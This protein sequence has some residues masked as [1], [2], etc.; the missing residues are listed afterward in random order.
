MKSLVVLATVISTIAASSLPLKFRF[1]GDSK[2]NVRSV[3]QCAEYPDT[4]LVVVSGS[5][6]DMVCMPGKMPMDVQTVIKNDLPNDLT[7]ML[8]LTK[9]DPF[10]LHV[11]CLNGVGSC[12]MELC[13]IIESTP[14]LCESFPEYQPCGCPLLAG[15]MDLAGVMIDV[16][17]MGDIMGAVMSGNYEAT[18]T[19]YGASAPDNIVGCVKMTFA[20]SNSC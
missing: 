7:M 4:D 12:P 19:L 10:P 20:L 1:M 14:A 16:P 17:D 8:D 9:L 13:P 11:P 18:M 6:P 3:E 5:T 2:A 15:E